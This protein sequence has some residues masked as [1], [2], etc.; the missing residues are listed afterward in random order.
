VFY[1]RFAEWRWTVW[2]GRATTSMWA[3]YSLNKDVTHLDPDDGGNANP[4]DTD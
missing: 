3:S 4:L 1:Q 2:K